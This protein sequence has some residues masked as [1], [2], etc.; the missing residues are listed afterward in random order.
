MV[1]EDYGL[2]EIA[3]NAEPEDWLEVQKHGH[4]VR[5]ESLTGWGEWAAAYTLEMPH[6]TQWYFVAE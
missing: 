3:A 6:I 2:Y 1:N 5:Q 4:V